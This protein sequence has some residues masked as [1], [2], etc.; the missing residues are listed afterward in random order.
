MDE[1]SAIV[2]REANLIREKAFSLADKLPSAD[3]PITFKIDVQIPTSYQIT[4]KTRILLSSLFCILIILICIDDGVMTHAAF[5]YDKDNEKLTEIRNIF[6]SPCRFLGRLVG[7]LIAL[8]IIYLKQRKYYFTFSIFLSFIFIAIF[9]IYSPTLM[10]L[11]G[12]FFD[13]VG[14]FFVLSLE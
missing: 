13:N 12:Y 2:R 3:I 5:D 10:V 1:Q 11:F 8:P 6:K 9:F 4:E 7:N 14:N